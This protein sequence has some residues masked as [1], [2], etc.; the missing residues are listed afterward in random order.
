MGD[1][2]SYRKNKL[3]VGRPYPHK[4][5]PWLAGFVYAIRLDNQYVKIGKTDVPERRIEKVI[6]DID[7]ETYYVDNGEYFTLEVQRPCEVW[8]WNTPI[9]KAIEDSVK[10]VCDQFREFPDIRGQQGT[11]YTEIFKVDWNKFLNIVRDIVLMEYLKIKYIRQDRDVQHDLESLFGRPYP[12]I[13]I[14]HISDAK[15]TV[16]KLKL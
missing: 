8:Y 16:F 12:N 7:G 11:L 9:T 13:N 1:L 2:K 3:I 6:S 4:E 14:D 15:Y 5:K 10:S